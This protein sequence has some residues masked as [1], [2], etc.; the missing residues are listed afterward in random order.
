MS[1]TLMR[2]EHPASSPTRFAQSNQ[3]FRNKAVAKFGGAT[4]TVIDVAER[5]AA[6]PEGL[7]ADVFHSVTLRERC[8]ASRQRSVPCQTTRQ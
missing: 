2:Q 3:M 8:P 1:G 4:V 5:T 7:G 6:R